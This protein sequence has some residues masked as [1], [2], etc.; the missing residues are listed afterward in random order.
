MTGPA[1]APD[2][3]AI[4][5]FTLTLH[6]TDRRT[7]AE[8]MDACEP[9]AAAEVRRLLW[10]VGGQES[11][12]QFVFD[13]AWL[14][15][16]KNAA[17][18]WL[19]C[20]EVFR[21]AYELGRRGGLPGLAQGAARAIA[22]IT[23]ENLN[24][25]AEALRL[26][27]AMAAEIGW[28]P[29]QKDGRA[30]I[31]LRTGDAAGA[32]ASWRTLLP[33]WTP[34]DEFDLQQPFSHRQAAIA[35]AR[36]DKWAEAA[37][38]LRS[39]RE[40]A[41]DVN[42]AIYCAGLLVDEGYA[43]W[44]GGDDR[45]ALSRLVEGFAA[46]DRLPSD[47]ADENAYLLRKRAGH[48]IMWI[49]NAAAGT[50]PKGFSA[51]PP[52]CSSSLE[53]VKEA[54]VPSTPSDAMWAHLLEFEFVAKLGDDLF[55]THEARLK[56]SQYG[57]IRFT[58]DKLRVQRRL[59][60][61]TIADFVEVVGD[62]VESSALCRLYYKENGLGAADPLPADVAPLDRQ[63][64]NSEQVLSGMLNAVF[65]LAARDAVTEEVLAMWADS[66]ARARLSAILTPWLQFVGDL[67]IG[68]S[69]D[70]E[71]AVRDQS[72]AWSWQAVASVR[73]AI[74][75]TTRPAELLTIHGYWANVL[76]KTGIGLFVLA[77]IEHLITSAWR[78]LAEEQR[79]LLRAPAQTVPPLQQACASA[80]TG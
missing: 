18:D 69:I 60:N 8:L 12:A 42:Q 55:R 63:Q 4:A 57:L 34:K 28:S 56:A 52:A 13:R 75:S 65:V 11:T 27:D 71:K 20:R 6:L 64:L 22:R 46:I 47:D 35:A 32:L 17:P 78:R 67:F 44:K 79:F 37:D 66:A 50:P 19:A 45:S 25:P 54:R 59:G 10:F 49:A 62:W 1:G 48:T 26:A 73:V 23:D 51:P 76:P 29:G 40:L 31:L 9:L 33:S 77:E 70:A 21:R 3:A 24:V 80:S 53:P 72:L 68:N 61:M 58:F 5:G 43:R 14:A 36:L 74:D 30:S 39:A 16:F 41:D 15:E 38:W 7:L 2:M